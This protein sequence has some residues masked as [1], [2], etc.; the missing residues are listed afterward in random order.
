MKAVK[1]LG[2]LAAAI[3][4]LIVV[5]ALLLPRFFDSDDFRNRVAGEFEKATGRTLALEEDLKLKVFPWLGVELGRTRVGNAPGFGDQPFAEIGTAAVGVRLMPLLS[6]EVEVSDVRLDGLSLN[7]VRQADGTTNW[8]DLAGGGA[9]TETPAQASGASAF[10]PAK[11][12]IAG[13]AIRDARVSFDDR[14]AGQRQELSVPELTTGSI[15]LG[16]P[17]DVDVRLKAAVDQPP[18]S[19]DAGIGLNL[20]VDPDLARF[21]IR[22]LGVDGTLEGDTLPGGRQDL[23]VSAGAID[24]D[25]DAQTLALPEL[26]MAALGLDVTLSAAG[27]QI[28]DAPEVTGQLT[29]EPFSPREL[30]VAMGSE[31]PVTADEQVLS[32]LEAKAGFRYA[33]ETAELTELTG[34]LDDSAFSGNASVGTGEPTRIR[35]SLAVDGIDVDRYLPPDS[36]AE[37]TEDTEAAS[38]TPLPLEALEGLD[39]EAA[40]TIGTVKALDLNMKDVK[41]ELT[42]KDGRLELDPVAASLYE[43]T[44]EMSLTLDGRQSP[45]ALRLNQRLE[46]VAIGPLLKD[47]ADA[48]QIAG[49]AV[50]RM[51]VSARG[52]STNALLADLDGDVRFAVENGRLVG[53]NLWYEISRAYA[54]VKQNPAP[55][56]TSEDTEFKDLRGSAVLTDGIAR[57]NDLQAGTPFLS[58][59]GGGKVNLVEN[60]LDMD[61]TAAVLKT[62]VDPATGEVSEIAGESVPIRISG[63][64][65]SPKVRPDTEAI[66]RSEAEDLIK[67]QLDLDE[68]KSL[69]ESLEEEARKKL[70][71]LFD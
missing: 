69:Q 23:R 16:E 55:Q 11:L 5:A 65:D 39:V 62:A 1:I 41:A 25:L 18:A 4:L 3:V 63:A 7:L 61:L 40:L 29:L 45:A 14:Q 66:V 56:K 54:L 35:A 58:L 46:N 22:D 51:N 28:V 32:R 20:K 59:T 8:D 49:T 57:T 21:E 36:E 26:A 34:N 33:G 37:A 52:N 30:M 15:A 27:R 60:S 38:D 42:I 50:T 9:E 10:D 31:A 12:R 68:D 2:W 48:G 67:D 47:F 24:L 64:L 13:V 44:T 53:V 6:G 70:K 71:K 43:G 17:F 19:L